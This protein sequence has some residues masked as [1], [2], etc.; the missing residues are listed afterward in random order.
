MENKQ[1]IIHFNNETKWAVEGD[2]LKTNYDDSGRITHYMIF[3]K[4]ELVCVAPSTATV[5]E[6]SKITLQIFSNPNKNRD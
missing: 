2:N 1:Y 6:G 3:H 4:E 5:I